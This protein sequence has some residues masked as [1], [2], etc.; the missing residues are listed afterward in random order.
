[1]RIVFMGTPDYSV[2]TLEA[3]LKAGHEIVGVYAQPDKPV[4]RK[5]ILTPPPVKVYAEEKGIPVFQPNTLKDD[6]VFEELKSLAPELIVVVAYGKILPE[7]ILNIAK[8]GCINGHASILPKYRGASPIQ[9]CIVQGETE[10]GVTIM[11]M[12]KGMDTG[13]IIEIERVKIGDDET[14]DELFDR[15][16]YVSADLTVATI[17]KIA[18]GTAKRTKQDESKATY[19][20][21][22]TK[23]MAQIDFTKTA[24]EVKNAVRGF[25]SWPCAYFFLDGKRVKVLKA[26]VEN[27]TTNKEC[28]TVI[29]CDNKLLIAC[30]EGTVLSLLEVQPEGSKAMNIATMLNGRKIPVGTKIERV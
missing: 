19:A 24:W 7:R 10:T 6:A 25:N 20:P 8:Y 30:G 16:S 14:A 22:L 13:D 29:C 15:L 17:E 11:Y 1:M 9:W 12:D 18:N 28:G 2:K 26:D 23:D 27:I 5:R 21:I 3:L 4:G